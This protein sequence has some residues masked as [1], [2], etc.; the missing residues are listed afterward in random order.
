MQPSNAEV[1]VLV[2]VGKEVSE[3]CMVFAVDVQQEAGQSA[4]VLCVLKVL[5]QA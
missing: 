1:H 2:A 4:L 3:V 5:L